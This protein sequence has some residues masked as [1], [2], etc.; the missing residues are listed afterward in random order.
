MEKVMTTTVTETEFSFELQKMSKKQLIDFASEK[1]GL[2][3]EEKLPKEEIHAAIMKA[4]DAVVD[5]AKKETEESA[6]QAATTED[7][8]VKIRF[9]NLETPGAE[10]EFNFD[11]GRGVTKGKKTPKY[12]LIDQET[13]N[14]PYSVYE[15]LNNLVVPDSKYDV[16]PQTGMIRGVLNGKKRRFTCELLL[17][18]SQILALSKG[19]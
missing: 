4:R 18:K 10:L 7:P 3:V 11:S 13:H 9:I 15:H 14:V 8:I 1:Y 19:K 6:K 16:D 5:F 17:D 2:N 12:H